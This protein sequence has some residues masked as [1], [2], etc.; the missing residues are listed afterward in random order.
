MRGAI[1]KRFSA[2]APPGALRIFVL[3]FGCAA[4]TCACLRRPRAQRAGDEAA[5]PPRQRSRRTC[6]KTVTYLYGQFFICST[7]KYIND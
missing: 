1:C 2:N 3:I 6:I 7:D 4:G 5:Q